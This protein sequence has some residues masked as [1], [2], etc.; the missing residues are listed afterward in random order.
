MLQLDS[1]E[2]Q[3][4][5]CRCTDGGILEI[6][7]GKNE[8]IGGRGCKRSGSGGGSEMWC[9]GWHWGQA[10]CSPPSNRNCKPLN[11]S[12]SLHISHL[13]LMFMVFHIST[14]CVDLSRRICT[15]HSL[16]EPRNIRTTTWR[17]LH[18]SMGNTM[19]N[20]LSPSRGFSSQNKP[21]RTKW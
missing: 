13:N 14:L 10:H 12:T 16:I 8:S 1:P 20:K 7:A 21:A 4:V 11:F 6:A 3:L 18:T 17:P 19:G 15:R 9:H 2:F 5:V